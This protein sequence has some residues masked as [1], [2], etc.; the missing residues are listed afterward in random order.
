MISI[1]WTEIN[2]AGLKWDRQR[3]TKRE[4]ER[5]EDRMTLLFSKRHPCVF[6]SLVYVMEVQCVSIYK[7]PAQRGGL[8]TGSSCRLMRPLTECGVKEGKRRGETWTNLSFIAHIDDT[9]SSVLHGAYIFHFNFFNKNNNNNKK[10]TNR[11]FCVLNVNIKN[12]V[13]I[14]FLKTSV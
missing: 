8:I 9:Y 1:C 4:R 13:T 7:V 6:D 12:W 10:K 3:E 2:W 5:D 11:I 14:R